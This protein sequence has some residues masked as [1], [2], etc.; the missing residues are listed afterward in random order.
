MDIKHYLTTGEAAEYLTQQLEQKVKYYDLDN[1]IRSG[2]IESPDK[3]GGRRVW[4]HEKLKE[5]AK[6]LRIRRAKRPVLTDQRS[7]IEQD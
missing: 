5:A 7:L 3:I 1:L 4:S 6:A 2:A